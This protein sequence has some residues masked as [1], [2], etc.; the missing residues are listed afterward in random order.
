MPETTSYSARF[1]DPAAVAAYESKEYGTASY[2]SYV[3]QWQR[4]VVEQ[5]IKTRQQER[6]TPSRLLDFACG[7]GRVLAC[8]ET[9]VDTAEGIDISENMVALARAK[10]RKAQFKVGDILSQPGLLQHDYDFITAFRFLLNVEP[11]A[12]RAVLRK[13][14]EVARQPD[15]LL[16]INVHG[17]SRS[18]RHP[19]ILWRRW[20]ERTQPTGAMLNEMSPDEARTLLRECGFQVVRQFGFGILPP[21]LYRTPLRGPAAMVDRFFAGDNLWRDGAIDM[22][23]VCQPC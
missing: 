16:L 9:L 8:V 2:A 13:L 14:R 6:N 19:A 22:M 23:F 11:A 20:R 17:N 12:R 7:T 3:W 18:L 10:C 4:P 15:S 21:T 5:I 1:Q